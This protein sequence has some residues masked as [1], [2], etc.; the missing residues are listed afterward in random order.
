MFKKV[1]NGSRYYMYIH[2]CICVCANICNAIEKPF[3]LWGT[4]VIVRIRQGWVASEWYVMT[5]EL[6]LLTRLAGYLRKGT[7]EGGPTDSRVQATVAFN[8]CMA[9]GVADKEVKDGRRCYIYMCV[10][11][12]ACVNIYRNSL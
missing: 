1:K 7:A 5:C 9:S 10:C 3:S 8:L 6:N 11:M 2:M 4:N 12:C